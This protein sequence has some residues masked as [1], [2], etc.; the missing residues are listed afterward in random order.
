MHLA[1]SCIW[2]SECSQRCGGVAV[3]LR[4]LAV[5]TRSGPFLNI[6]VDV[7]PHKMACY[8]AL[9]GSNSRVGH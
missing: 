8:H 4:M 5:Q 2:C 6:R 9:S 3:D 7:W 1:N